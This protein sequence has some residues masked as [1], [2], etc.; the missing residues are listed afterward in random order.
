LSPKHLVD[1]KVSLLTLLTIDI[2]SRLLFKI[3]V[4]V[5]CEVP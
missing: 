5:L 4:A 3:A 2:T 1:T